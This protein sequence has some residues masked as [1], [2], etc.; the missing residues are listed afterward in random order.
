MPEMQ[1][2]RS[3]L[4]RFISERQTILT[5][6]LDTDTTKIP[7][8]LNGDVLGFNKKIIEATHDLC[9]AYK[10]NFAFYESLGSKGWDI[11]EKTIQ[12]IPSTHLI[13]ADAKRGDI[14]NT[15]E[16]YARSIYD[17][18]GCDAI[19]VSPYMGSDSV[20]PFYR[21]GKWVIILAL[22]S[23]EG[24][25]DFQQQLLK[26]GKKLHEEVMETSSKWGSADDTMYVLGATHPSDIKA[27]RDKYPDHI[28]LVPGVGAQ[29]GDLNAICV[30]GLNEQGGLL[31]NASRSI[32]YASNGSD[33]AEEGRKEAEKMNK[34]TLKYLEK[35]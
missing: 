22:T 24:S 8:I 23:N 31:I 33:F 29:G 13:I 32:L 1:K 11:L 3:Y 7:S 19:T 28:F 17:H 20:K 12:C 25:K 10:L 14:G 2:T 4:A 30:A 35:N 26:N 34:I 6:G 18:L 16:M 5:I 9:V 27:I 15:S 21:D